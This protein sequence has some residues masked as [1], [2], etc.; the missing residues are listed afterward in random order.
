MLRQQAKSDELKE[1]N[2]GVFSKKCELYEEVTNL[3]IDVM[4][5]DK[6]GPNEAAQ[7]KKTLYV[8]CLFFVAQRH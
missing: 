7:I 1:Q 8:G 4:E 3:L 2:V 5:D 6:I